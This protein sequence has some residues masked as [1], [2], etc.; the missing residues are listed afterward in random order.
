MIDPK[1]PKLKPLAELPETL[2]AL[3]INM[4]ERELG[5]IPETKNLIVTYFDAIYAN[6]PI[7]EDYYIHEMVHFVRQGNG[8]NE[9]LAR[10]FCIKYCEDKAFRYQEELMAYREQW[11]FVVQKMKFNKAKAF[12]VARYFATELSSQK[13]GNIC[14]FHQAL[15]DIIKQ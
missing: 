13:Y 9:S 1:Q 5:E 3:L 8:E 15:A 7:P 2:M 6:A 14:S 11:K 12:D 4:W 10:T